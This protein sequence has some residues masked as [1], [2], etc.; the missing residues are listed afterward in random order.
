M[1]RTIMIVSCILLVW[2]CKDKPAIS[3]MIYQGD[4]TLPGIQITH[5]NGPQNYNGFC[6]GPQKHW[7]DSTYVYTHGGPYGTH[8]DTTYVSVDLVYGETYVF[9]RPDARA[10][11]MSF[12][13]LPISVLYAGSVYARHTEGQHFVLLNNYGPPAKLVYFGDTVTLES[14]TSQYLYT[15]FKYREMSDTVHYRSDTSFISGRFIRHNIGASTL[16]QDIAQ[17]YYCGVVFIKKPLQPVNFSIARKD[18]F[19]VD[20]LL[21][22]LSEATGCQIERK[23]KDLFVY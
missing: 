6:E 4:L 17:I 8:L 2:C 9:T 7:G 20:N 10:L 1:I 19:Y 16:I 14:N 18:F 12:G 15:R 22:M 21:P 23:G 13:E 3:P 11:H 5:E